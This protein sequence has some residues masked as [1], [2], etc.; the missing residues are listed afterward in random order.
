MKRSNVFLLGMPAL[1]TFVVALSGCATTSTTA[2]AQ[3]VSWSDYTVHTSKDY[4]VVGTVV[5]RTDDPKT[6]NADLMEKAIEL[7][8]H[9]I[10]NVRVDVEKDNQ[11]KN[12]ILAATAVAIKYTAE[13]I[14][15][16]EGPVLGVSGSSPASG[17]AP[18]K[19][20][21]GVF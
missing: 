21:L 11:G 10:I 18:R 2:G 7:G 17:A 20:F 14:T 9:D 6:L 5:I 1:L 4:T 16:N 15:T 13:T 19:K 8:A 12:K 3:E